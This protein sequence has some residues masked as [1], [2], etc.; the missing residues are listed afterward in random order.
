MLTRSFLASAFVLLLFTLVWALDVPVLR[1]RV[2]DYAGVMQANQVQSLESQ[3]AQL[4]RDTG[5]QVVVVDY[6]TLEGE[7]IEGYS[8]PCR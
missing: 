6:P 5:H 4:E 3:L 2:N 7:D 8:I 1:G